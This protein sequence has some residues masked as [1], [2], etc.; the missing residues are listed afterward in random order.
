M[1]RDYQDLIVRRLNK[2]SAPKRVVVAGAADEHA[3]EAVFQAQRLGYVTPVLVGDQSIIKSLIAASEFKDESFSIKH[4]QAE[5]N[6]AAVAVKLIHAGQGDFI[7][8][9][10]LETR[11]LLKPIL[12]KESGLN[13]SGFITHFGLMQIRGYHKLL[14]MSDGAV[15]P[16][17]T[18]EQKAQIVKTA[19]AQL[20]K[21]G[22][23]RPVVAALCATEKVNPQMPETVHAEALARMCEHQ[24]LGDCQLLGP[25]SYDLATSKESADIKG[26]QVSGAGDADMLLVPQ[27]VSGNIISKIWNTDPKCILSGCLVGA[28]VPV[29]LTSRSAGMPEK[30]HSLVLCSLLT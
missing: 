16:H 23:Q 29:G 14:A 22:Y 30:L 21:L 13:S 9:G 2:L 1:Y 24:E 27:M 10:K 4:C 5:E 3:L 6:P 17:P 7:L 19:V 28:D 18:L 11:D 15:I 20:H 26:Y 25:V 8:K 12:N